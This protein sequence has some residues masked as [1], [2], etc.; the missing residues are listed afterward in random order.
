MLSIGEP[1]SP[2]GKFLAQ[3]SNSQMIRPNDI[4]GIVLYI[5]KIFNEK[6]KATN[7]FPKLIKWS[8]KALTKRLSEEILLN[9]KNN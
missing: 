7:Y 1:H 3:G 8:R 5:E 4:K 6:E 2:A 9:S